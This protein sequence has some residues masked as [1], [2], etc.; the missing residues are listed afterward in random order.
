MKFHDFQCFWRL[1]KNAFKGAHWKK[2]RLEPKIENRSDLDLD[3]LS[4]TQFSQ[5]CWWEWSRGMK[6][7]NKGKPKFPTFFK[8]FKYYKNNDFWML[9]RKN[10]LKLCQLSPIWTKLCRFFLTWLSIF[11]PSPRGCSIQM[12][13]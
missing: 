2:N 9:K 11:F 1:F 8:V 13:N 5:I 4:S 6:M 7:A 10:F 12:L 3:P